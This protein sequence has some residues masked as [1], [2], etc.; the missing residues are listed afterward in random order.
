MKKQINRFLYPI[1]LALLSVA[2]AAT[3][4]SVTVTCPPG[5]V[6]TGMPASYTATV[7]GLPPGST[8]SRYIWKANV[9]AGPLGIAGNINGVAFNQISI[10]SSQP[11]STVTITWGDF[12]PST[13]QMVD[14]SVMYRNADDE[15]FEISGNCTATVRRIGDFYV[16]GP[17]LVQE[18]C[19]DVLTY[20]AVG[21]GDGINLSGYAFTWTFPAGWTVQ[22][23]A[24]GPTIQL[25]PDATTG[26]NVQCTIRRSTGNPAYSRTDFIT[27]QRVKAET[28]GDFLQD[29]YCIGE[30][31]EICL[32]EV[33]DATGATWT[34]PPSLLVIDGLGTKC[35]KF[36]PNP[37]VVPGTPG[38]ISAQVT[39]EGGCIATVKNHNFTI[40]V[41]ET[42]PVPQGYITVDLE[43]GSD[44]C[45]DPIY[46]VNF[47]TNSPYV[48]GVTRVSPGI[49]LGK[50]TEPILISVCNINLCSREKS[51]IY[52][53]IDPPPPCDAI[54][55]PSNAGG[56][57]DPVVRRDDMTPTASHFRDFTVSPNPTGG[58]FTLFLPSVLSGE[59]LLHDQAGKTVL[60]KAFD[61]AQTIP[62]QPDRALPPGVYFLK[63]VAGGE[64]VT[65]KVVVR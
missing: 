63:I 33:C 65:K 51:C 32:D 50:R 37:S 23:A 19:D 49:I 5:P 43:E 26:G 17:E 61:A 44:P 64:I 4:Q 6:E 34:V 7:S 2:G 15:L 31:Y 40:Y 46:L 42:P 52:F 24:N 48:N 38:T 1:T 18:C 30:E 55:K 56:G 22:G 20:T 53:W 41:P 11:T 3:A 27:V 10:Q 14:V 54:G 60:H 39:L 8:I 13:S 45:N 47:H 29:F 59:L 57:Q 9:A 21:Y 16:D 12:S 28:K 36:T 62:V 58:D 25:I 35:L